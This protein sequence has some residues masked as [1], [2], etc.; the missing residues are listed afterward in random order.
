MSM[1]RIVGVRFSAPIATSAAMSRP[2]VTP[3]LAHRSRSC[4][5]CAEADPYT[6]LHS[7]PRVR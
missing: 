4:P 1:Y 7:L 6:L 3:G 2:R 5:G